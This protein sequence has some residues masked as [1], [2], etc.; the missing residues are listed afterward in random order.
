MAPLICLIV[1]FLFF[2]ILG[3]EWRYFAD[4]HVALRAALGAMFLLVPQSLGS[5]GVWVTLTGIAEIAIAVGLQIHGVAPWVATFAVVMLCCLSPA[6]VKAAR[7]H[8]TILRKPVLSV[9]PRLLIQLVFIAALIAVSGRGGESGFRRGLHS[10]VCLAFG[11]SCH[12][13]HGRLLKESLE[14]QSAGQTGGGYTRS[15][16]FWLRR[17][18]PFPPYLLGWHHHDLGTCR[19]GERDS[20]SC[21]IGLCT[22]VRFGSS[23]THGSDRSV[24]H[25]RRKPLYN[26]TLGYGA[27]R[28]RNRR[29]LQI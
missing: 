3:L 22:R 20:G 8:L 14:C 24:W 16:N 1:S 25:F 26:D 2:R 15:P 27:L 18:L 11:Y 23:M 9:G 17:L 6:D 12:R 7:E 13:H 21:R 10:S 28:R 4:W 5:P 29:L 19:T